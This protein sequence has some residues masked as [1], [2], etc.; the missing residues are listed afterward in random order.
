MGDLGPAGQRVGGHGVVVVLAGDLDL[1][2]RQAPHRVVAAVVAEGQ[3]VRCR[4]PRAR[5]QQL[6][7]EADAE[8]RHLG[9]AARRWRRR[10]T[11]TA[12]G[13]PG[14]LD[15][16]T[17]SGS[18]ASTSAAGVDGRHHLDRGRARPSWRRIVALIAE[19]VGDDPAAARRRPCRARRGDLGDEVD[20]VGAGLGERGRLAASASSAVPNAPGMAP[21]SR[22]WR[23]RRRVSTPAMPGTPWRRR[24][25][26]R[27]P[28]LRQL[29]RP[30][31]QVA[32]DDAAAERPAALVVGGGDAVVADVRVGEGDDLAG[33]GRVGDAPPGSR[34][35]RC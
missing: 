1:P 23:V 13:S 6:V 11:A 3:L 2:G 27:S 19:V 5:G 33:V 15:R 14:P 24:K 30:P 21:A 32:H 28:S 9:R 7:A 20:A 26:S 17:P 12:A 8:D 4:P 22:R 31:G 18:R 34:T 16:N 25:A 29:L 35:G 10:R